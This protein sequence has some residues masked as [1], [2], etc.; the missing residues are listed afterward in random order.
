MMGP[1]SGNG[2]PGSDAARFYLKRDYV[3][4]TPARFYVITGLG[5]L[6]S[7]R[8]ALFATLSS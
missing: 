8:G 4:E 7:T 2:L 5:Y 6:L 1:H 3:V